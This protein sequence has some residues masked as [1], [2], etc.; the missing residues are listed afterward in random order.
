MKNTVYL[1]AFVLLSYVK[2]T[3]PEVQNAVNVM[4][5]SNALVGIKS[6]QPFLFAAAHTKQY[7]S[8]LQR[9]QNKQLYLIMLLNL[10]NLWVL[11]I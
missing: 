1:S 8:T 4:E 9:L 3:F 2:I 10:I 5:I 11:L 6:L 7:K